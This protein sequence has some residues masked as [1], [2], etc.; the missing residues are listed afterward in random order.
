MVYGGVWG[1]RELGKG[2]IRWVGGWE[3]VEWVESEKGEEGGEEVL[4]VV[5]A[6]GG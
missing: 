6:M 5:G 3:G 1:R 4:E 2:E